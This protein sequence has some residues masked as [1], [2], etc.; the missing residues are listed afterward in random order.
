MS[1]TKH[2]DFNFTEGLNTDVSPEHM[3]EGELRKAINLDFSARG[4]IKSRNGYEILGGFNSYVTQLIEFPRDDG[5]IE[6]L[7]VI[8]EEL[9]K[10]NRDNYTETSLQNLAS[11]RVGYFIFQDKLYFIDGNEYYVYDG[12]TVEPV[13]PY[14]PDEGETNNLE[15]IKKCKYCLW[16][17]KSHRFFFAGNPDDVSAVYYS[18]PNMPNWVQEV[19]KIYPTTSDGKIKGIDVL[20][21]SV[22]VFYPHSAWSYRGLDPETDAIW[23]KLALTQGLTNDRAKSMT[24]GSLTF[25]GSEDLYAITPNVLG[26]ESTVM[27]GDDYV[28][29]LTAD[30][31]SNVLQAIPDMDDVHSEYD[32]DNDLYHLVYDYNKELIFDFNH[33]L[34]YI[35]EYDVEGYIYDMLHTMEGELLGAI[36]TDLVRF[37]SGTEDDNSNINFKIQTPK[38][39]FEAPFNPKVLSQIYCSFK[40]NENINFEIKIFADDSLQQT[41]FVEGDEEGELYSLIKPVNITGNRFHIEIDYEGSEKFELY[42]LGF[43]VKPTNRYGDRVE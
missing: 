35:N 28:A 10:I 34:F 42:G 29:N 2:Y 36:H 18:E 24:P 41:I 21:D 4:A 15:P 1:K 27:V 40:N 5:S 25:L 20:M 31:A 9:Y 38:Y 23:E 22:I 33:S 37:K 17:T 19:N 6:L 11:D 12:D 26:V 8:G 14:E 7:A 13:D 3:S 43:D 30:R 32:S 39:K 16:H